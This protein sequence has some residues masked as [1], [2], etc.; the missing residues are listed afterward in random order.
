MNS[1]TASGI[2]TAIILGF[3]TLICP[4]EKI[5]G[6]VEIRAVFHNPGKPGVD[7]FIGEPNGNF[8]ELGL[9]PE[10]LSPPQITRL[11][12]G[13]LVIYSKPPA[14]PANPGDAV[15]ATCRIPD[16]VKQAII[17]VFPSPADAKLPYAAVLIN[18]SS[19]AFQ[20]GQS[21]VLNLTSLEMAVRA[22]EHR[23]PLPSGEIAAIPA[24]TKV[25]DFNMAQ[26]N[27]YVKENGEWVPVTER[28]LQFLDSTR[29][30]FMIYL[31]A[32]AS[33]PFVTTIVD[34]TPEVPIKVEARP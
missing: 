2:L 27:F 22:G 4:A 12:K 24:V 7:L 17:L 31:T 26:T 14:D 15:A 33:Q 28:K 21:R 8:A 9:N 1:S 18:N 13:F 11:V 23:L 32:G 16:G 10:G 30:I 29:R 34:T 20:K 25:D 6:A 5:A 3:S 19:A